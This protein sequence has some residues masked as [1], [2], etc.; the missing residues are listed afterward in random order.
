MESDHGTKGAKL[1]EQTES[2]VPYCSFGGTDKCDFLDLSDRN[3]KWPGTNTV[4]DNGEYYF[5]VTARGKNNRTWDGNFR[6]RV[7]R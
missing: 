5:E 6:F 2:A 3:A 4:I 1:F 7:Q